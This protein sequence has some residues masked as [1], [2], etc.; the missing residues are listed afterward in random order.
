MI[1]GYT[2]QHFIR[3]LIDTPIIEAPAKTAPDVHRHFT[4][5]SKGQFDG[6]VIK[7]S[8]TKGK[9]TIGGSYEYE[10]EILRIAVNF[11]SDEEIDVSGA[12]IAGEDYS[13][14]IK[15]IGLGSDWLP[16]KSKGQT[17]NY[18]T[19]IKGDTIK[20]AQL[21]QIVEDLSPFA[22]CLL[23]FTSANKE[24]VLSTKK[25]PPRPSNK[26]PDESSEENRVKFCS[27]KMN[28]S[29]DIL[30]FVLDGSA[31]DFL[32]EIPK[33]WKTMVI[34]SSYDITDLILP[35]DEKDSRLLR[36]NTVRKGTI[37]RV[38]EVDGKTQKI[39]LQFAA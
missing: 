13:A 11:L 16:E 24:I 31:K 26:N 32:D 15:K 9:L 18:N 29:P 35:K 23:S 1:G 38:M 12:I 22:Y 17:T 36:I 14:I 21:K 5:Y 27:L 28:N 34:S 7:I 33:T 19:V 4:R 25:K 30:K 10:D 37:N 8:Q 20:K 39:K 3:K 6:P 2:M